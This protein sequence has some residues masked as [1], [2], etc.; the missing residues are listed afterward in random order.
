MA[1]DPVRLIWSLAGSGEGVTLTASGNS[2]SWSSSNPNAKS[3]VDLRWVDDVWMSVSVAGASGTTP[4]LKVNL[5]AF[6]DQGN[7]FGGGASPLLVAPASGSITGAGQTVVFGG[8]HG[9][10]GGS[11]FVLPE[12]GQVSWTL[13]G[14]SPSFTGVEIALYGRG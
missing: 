12:W 9:G 14:T 11:Y 3:P 7:L 4:T 8:R 5:N 13:G 1:D 2:G 10:S 6:D